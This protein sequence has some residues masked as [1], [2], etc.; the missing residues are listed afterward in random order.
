M[1]EKKILNIADPKTRP[2]LGF[3]VFALVGL[4]ISVVTPFTGLSPTGHIVF[5]SLLGAL[6]LW[7]FK[8]GNIPYFAGAIIIIV[9]CVAAGIS[10][11]TV[12]S[13]FSSASMWLLIPAM[14][15]GFALR[16]TGLGNRIAF[17]VLEKIKPS[18]P[19]ILMGWFVIGLLFSFLTP[20]STVRMLILCAV[21]VSV[22]D[23]CQL[24]KGTRGRSLIVI[25]AWFTAI[26][27]GIGWFTGSLNGP[28]LTGF[29]PAEMQ[30]LINPDIWLKTM[31]LPWIF[32]TIVFLIGL[33]F[34]LRPK[35]KLP[36]TRADMKRFYSDLGK[37]TPEEIATLVILVGVFLGLGFQKMHG[38][39]SFAIMLV[40]LFCLMLFKIITVPDIGNGI[41]WDIII[42]IGT[43]MGLSEI[44]AEAGIVDWIS[45]GIAPLTTLLATSPLIF[46]MGLMLLFTVLRF[47]D[48][49][50]GWTTAAL[51][52]TTTPML[53]SVYGI[54]PIILLFVFAAG[55]GIFFL[56]YQQPWIALTESVTKDAGWNVNHMQKAGIVF[57]GSVLLAIL[58]FVPYWQWIGVLPS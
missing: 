33:F 6:G 4:F 15:F 13:G 20:S 37:I 12:T 48:I 18:Y 10:I 3:L 47:L 30:A 23:A 35:E 26:F 49:T 36:V 32:I 34:V 38:L 56:S 42:F 57:F 16:K 31:C 17:F 52:S 24:A 2:Y 46:V 55:A 50:W 8:P 43:I 9:G 22:A 7:I 39:P 51:L 41:S 19:M 53:Y 11:K 21:A 29:L 27:I 28:V 45:A 58:V 40:G 44:F 25:S 5:G 14:F 54:H 1:S